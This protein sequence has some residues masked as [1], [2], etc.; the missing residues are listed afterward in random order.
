MSSF[1]FMVRE[2]FPVP[3]SD[4]LY[5][6]Y[7]FLLVLLQLFFFTFNSVIL[8]ELTWCTVLGKEKS[9]AKIQLNNNMGGYKVPS[10]RMTPS[11]LR[12]PPL[13]TGSTAQLAVDSKHRLSTW[14]SSSPG[15]KVH[16]CAPKTM[17]LKD[18][19][20][21]V[22]TKMGSHGQTNPG[23]LL[24]I[25]VLS[26]SDQLKGQRKHPG[27]TTN[28]R[29]QCG[30]WREDE[31]L[32]SIRRLL[33]AKCLNISYHLIDASGEAPIRRDKRRRPVSGAPGRWQV[34]CEEHQSRSHQFPVAQKLLTAHGP[35]HPREKGVNRPASRTPYRAMPSY[36]GAAPS[37]SSAQEV[38]TRSKLE[39]LDTPQPSGDLSHCPPFWS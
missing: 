3:R 1:V 30:Q 26:N 9:N 6:F 4:V 17:G 15:R 11:T 5:F 18:N 25:T 19:D 37:P 34:S 39:A 13:G 7:F 12:S 27:A 38:Q 2:D 33:R 31:A 20:V 21:T 32:K 23:S 29:R 10:E 36:E 14:F 22:K 24:K 28:T 16:C 35:F 8:L